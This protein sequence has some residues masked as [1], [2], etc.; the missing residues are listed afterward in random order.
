M[1]CALSAEFG[2]VCCSRSVDAGLIPRVVMALGGEVNDD[3]A[4]RH[5]SHKVKKC[6]VNNKVNIK[7]AGENVNKGKVFSLPQ[8]CNIDLRYSTKY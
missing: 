5:A 6:L 8:L 2:T 4:S 7:N 1:H 3:N